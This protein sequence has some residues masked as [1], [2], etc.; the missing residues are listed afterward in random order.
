MQTIVDGCGCHATTQG[1]SRDRGLVPAYPYPI[2]L[3][4]FSTWISSTAYL[5]LA[6]MIAA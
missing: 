3:I 6:A 5:A 1:N 2:V 4:I